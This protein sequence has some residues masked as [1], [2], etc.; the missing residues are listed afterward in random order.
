MKIG[1][2]GSIIRDYPDEKACYVANSVDEENAAEIKR[3]EIAQRLK[4]GNQRNIFENMGVD[5]DQSIA[6]VYHQET[7][8]LILFERGEVK[9]NCGTYKYL[10]ENVFA[11]KTKKIT[12]EEFE[13]IEANVHDVLEVIIRLQE[14]FHHSKHLP[15]EHSADSLRII[16]WDIIYQWLCSCPIKYKENELKI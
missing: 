15:F 3:R 7:P 11:P 9:F 16:K 8:A 13:T 14:L 5:G 1:N 10:I 2:D 4:F 12:V 6:I